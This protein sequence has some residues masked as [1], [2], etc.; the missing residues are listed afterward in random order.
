ML[1]LHDRRLAE[2][3]ARLARVAAVGR[4][5]RPVRSDVWPAVADVHPIELQPF[6]SAGDRIFALMVTGKSAARARLAHASVRSF[7]LQDYG[8]RALVVVNDG[9]FDVDVSA[10]PA[11]RV[12]VVRPDRRQALGA[13]RNLGLDAIPDGA[14]WTYWDDDDWHHPTLLGAQRAAL[15]R[16]GVPACFLSYQI[17]YGFVP[18]A[19]FVDY[20]PGGFA[21]TLMAL[22]HPSL[23][24]PP[25]SS[26][27]DSVYTAAL[28]EEWSWTSWQN[29]A[30]Y[31]LRFFHG[32]NTW[33]ARHFGLAGDTAG[34]WDLAAGSAT[35]LRSVLPFYRDA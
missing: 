25:V 24:F 35:D 13:L 1:A 17:K 19:A 7:L 28:K 34:R 27:E 6:S 33:N 30:H 16:M 12:V 32:E 20:H 9:P 29:P 22:K 8:N 11:D 26:G 3:R 4:G 14:L 2:V 23:R 18:D 5:L 15:A 10:I 21:G 31:F